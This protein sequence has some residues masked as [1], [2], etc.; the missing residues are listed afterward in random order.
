MIGIVLVHTMIWIYRP[1]A[2]EAPAVAFADNAWEEISSIFGWFRLPLLFVI[3]GFLVSARIRA[4]WRDR[5]SLERAA[6]SYYLY[7]A[8][9][10]VYGVLSFVVPPGSPFRIWEP[11]SYV[12]QL[13]LPRTILWFI[14]ALALWALVLSALHRV[15]P[16]L[17]LVALAA[18]TVAT[19]WMPGNNGGD[20]YLRV[21]YFGF[22][23]ALGVY[24]KPAVAFLATGGLWWKI[25]AA[26]AVFMVL[27]K[28][29]Y[30]APNGRGVG[31]FFRMLEQTGAV[32]AAIAAVSLLCLIPVVARVLSAVGR[33]TLPIFVL[34]MPMFWLLLAIPGW[35]PLLLVP[36]LQACAPLLVVG[37]VVGG[38]IGLHR[39]IMLTPLR[40][41]FGMPSSW[42]ARIIGARRPEVQ[43][44][45]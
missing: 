14:L 39:L 19:D 4:G 3:S 43:P 17:M 1:A 28:L 21:L 41:L 45:V 30:A 27:R 18:L 44:V 26:G 40:V 33:N 32:A 23:F 31:T 22:F 7:V 16:V 25:I 8:W 13:V 24:L 38:S 11:A 6:S 12:R 34:Q 9:L 20:L 15:P 10:T 36:A 37:V 5:R 42:S 35:K 29:R 2:G